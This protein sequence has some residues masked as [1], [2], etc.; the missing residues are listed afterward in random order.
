MDREM[1]PSPKQGLPILEFAA[2]I[3][4]EVIVTTSGVRYKVKSPKI[5]I[6]NII[7]FDIKKMEAASWE[8]RTAPLPQDDFLLWASPKNG[9]P[10]VLG[11]TPLHSFKGFLCLCHYCNYLCPF[12]TYLCFPVYVTY[13]GNK[14]PDL[15]TREYSRL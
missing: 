5:N 15:S 14:F 4:K 7:Y 6:V 11:S 13:L 2:A 12:R 8:P 10:P 1:A 9:D 3:T